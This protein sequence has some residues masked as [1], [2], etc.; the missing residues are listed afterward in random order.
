MLLG[1]AFC[2]VFAEAVFDPPRQWLGAQINYLVEG[3]LIKGQFIDENNIS[4]APR[5]SDWDASRLGCEG[6]IWGPYD[7]VAHHPSLSGYT[8]LLIHCER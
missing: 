5:Q 4:T 3:F 1:A 2:G 6:V 7:K 8:D